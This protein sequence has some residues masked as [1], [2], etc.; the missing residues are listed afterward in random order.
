MLLAQNGKRSKAGI[1]LLSFPRTFSGYFMLR[2]V[3]FL[4]ER[5]RNGFTRLVKV[6]FLYK[7]CWFS[8]FFINFTPDFCSLA[9]MCIIGHVRQSTAKGSPRRAMWGGTALTRREMGGKCR[10][11]DILKRRLLASCLWH[12]RISQVRTILSE[13][14]NKDVLGMCLYASP[15]G[16]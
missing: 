1:L 9:L 12:P 14:G 16:V 13:Q 4:N 5:W 10:S 11:H 15:L 7:R 2:I 6:L 8:N 3:F